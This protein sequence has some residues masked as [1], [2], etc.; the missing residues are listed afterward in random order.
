MCRHVEADADLLL[1]RVLATTVDYTLAAIPPAA[2]GALV[3][4]R[5]RPVADAEP[6]AGLRLGVAFGLT[7]PAVAALAVGEARG[8]TPGKRLL[9]L[10]VS[11]PDGGPPGF[12]RAFA[13]LLAKTALPWELGHQSVWDLRGG[14]HTRGTVLA[15][16]A[17]VAVGA[18]LAAAVRGTG[19]TYADLVAGTRVERARGTGRRFRRP[20]DRRKDPAR[21]HPDAFHVG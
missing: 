6:T 19:R 9:G 3:L 11:G 5:G 17:H 13:R 2:L 18:Q 15:A 7:V 14:A 12:P 20:G 16:V 8:A 21:E 4:S 10:R 1:R